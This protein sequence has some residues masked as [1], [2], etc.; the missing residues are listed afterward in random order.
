MTALVIAM[1]MV[2]G[3]MSMAGA[4]NG[5][6]IPD[7]S[8][9][10]SGLEDQDVVNLYQVFKWDDVN[11]WSLT[12]DF[13]DLDTTNLANIQ[14][15]IDNDTTNTP[16]QLTKAELEA[17]ATYAKENNLSPTSGVASGADFTKSG[18]EPGMYLALVEPKTAGVIYN[19]LVVSVDYK[20]NESNEIDAS[21]AKMG[22]DSAVAKKD[23]VTVEKVANDYTHNTNDYV[24]FTV[25]TTIPVYADSYVNPK[26][27]VT[28]TLST[29]GLKGVVNTDD[30][31]FEVEAGSVKYTG[32]PSDGFTSFTLTFDT[33]DI[34]ALTTPQS[35]TIKYWAQITSDAP[36]TVNE[37]TNDVTV[38]YSNNPKNDQDYDTLYDE[39]KHWTFDI[40]GSLFG[41][42]SYT[43]GEVV[44]I[45][46]D[47]NGHILE[48]MVE[49]DNGS[50]HGA[51]ADAV[52][53]LYPEGTT[54]FTDANLYKNKQYQSGCKVTTTADGLMEIKGLDEG[55]Y[56]LK[57]ISAPA[58]YIKD[59]NEHTIVIDATYSEK[60]YSKVINGKTV[61]Y[62]VK[63]LDSY[64]VTIDGKK[65]STYTMTL[66]GPAISSVTPGDSSS[67]IQNTK[68][69]EL[70]S[71]GGM[72]TTLFY[73][74][75]A[76][77]VLGAGILLVSKRR[78][79]A[80]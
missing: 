73:A 13:E 78:M 14:A 17:L 43:T 79:S 68:G 7:S 28:D 47:E 58:G 40:D 6:L 52:F 46:V 80:N 1:V 39:T 53:G 66:S 70:P 2:V 9:T 35:V 24:Q 11:G 63:T 15:I 25:T 45:G 20:D 71:T 41:D 12:D 21:S 33:E 54:E 75:G 42:S 59:Q 10:I 72:G 64:T 65:T 55:T 30:H 38:E 22:S 23:T 5:N 51:L 77:L 49:L 50:E 27:N 62:K 3:T 31:K 69:V 16:I 74:I 8:V 36:F 32:T 4:A 61:Y 67:E 76:I 44:K 26:F 34:A 60:E 48:S 18:L 57:E 19:P 56:I 37:E 29:T